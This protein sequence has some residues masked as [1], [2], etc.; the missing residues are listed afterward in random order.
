MP[1]GT[2]LSP[3]QVAILYV[4]K[5][6]E[7]IIR[8]S[9]S[10]AALITVSTILNHE[11][12]AKA[13]VEQYLLQWDHPTIAG[14]LQSEGIGI[15]QQAQVWFVDTPL[16]GIVGHKAPA[17]QRN[18]RGA[19]YTALI[20]IMTTYYCRLYH[21]FFGD[22]RFMGCALDE[23]LEVL[24]HYKPSIRRQIVW[25][26][27]AY[28]DFFTCHPEELS[29]AQSAGWGKGWVKEERI[30]Q[31][32]LAGPYMEISPYHWMYYQLKTLM[33]EQWRNE[34]GQEQHAS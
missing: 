27:N 33:A 21:R 2:T 12:T 10:D 18:F 22:E 20:S 1:Y 16:P 15:S 14:H 26:E 8:L 19:V 24:Q 29:K 32:Y 31:I 25:F 17:E 34:H 4:D 6:R 5:H 11:D 9:Q 30:I 28:D 3:Y 23:L 13:I 7:R